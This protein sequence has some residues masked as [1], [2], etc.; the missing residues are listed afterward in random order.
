M[1]GRGKSSIGNYF[2]MCPQFYASRLRHVKVWGFASEHPSMDCE[3]FCKKVMKMGYDRLDRMGTNL[4]RAVRDANM[5][6]DFWDIINKTD[7]YNWGFWVNPSKLISF[8]W[9]IVDSL[10]YKHSFN[11]IF[12]D[13]SVPRSE[14]NIN[15]SKLYKRSDENEYIKLGK[16]AKKQK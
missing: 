7:C 15:F 16:M 11:D 12:I 5:Y 8:I 6:C 9:Q 4:R 1:L 14:L 13:N 10:D 2:Q 3:Q